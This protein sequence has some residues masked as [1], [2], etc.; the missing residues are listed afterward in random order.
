MASGDTLIV[1]SPY[2]G[3][4]PATLYATMDT[5]A[6]TSTPAEDIPVLDFDDTTQ[7]YIDFYCM[8][9]AHYG[10]GGV[11]VQIV[12]ST[13]DTTDVVAWQ[14]A[15]RRVADDAEDLDTTAQT[16]DY[17]EVIA[18]APSVVGEVAYDNITFTNGADMDSVAA[19]EYFILRVTRDP[20]PSSGTN[21]TGDASIHSILIKET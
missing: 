21:V 11:T 19:G 9:P 17:N 14:A 5:L 10:G 13:V 18:T 3:A 4:P 16:Y 12:F 8:M 1:L 7:E 15:F 20:T 2:D 6:G